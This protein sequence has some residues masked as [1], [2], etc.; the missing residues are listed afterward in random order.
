MSAITPNQQVT[1]RVT[2]RTDMERELDHAVSV[3]QEQAAME[4]PRG[5]LVTRHGADQFT[6]ALSDYVP[7]GLTVEKHNW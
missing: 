6:A 1:I 7:F 3:L 2:N 4:R 5:I